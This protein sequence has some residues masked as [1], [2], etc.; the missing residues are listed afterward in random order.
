MG[1]SNAIGLWVIIVCL[2]TSCTR[3]QPYPEE[4][5][6]AILR[7]EEQP[8]SARALLLL[9]DSTIRTA[10]E[11]TQMYYVLLRAEADDKLY[12][13]H[14]TDSMMLQVADYYHGKDN[15]K[16]QWAYYLLGRIYRNM[17]D[18]PRSLK[19]YQQ[20]LDSHP[21][22]RQYGL[23][24]RIYEQ[25]TYIYAEQDLDSLALEASTNCWRIYRLD[26]DTLG[27]AFALRNK[28]RIF[29]MQHRMDSM[30]S[31]YQKSY[32]T[33]R[34]M[35]DSPST[36]WILSEYISACMAHDFIEQGE[37]LLNALPQKMKEEDPITCYAVGVVY[38]HHN[39]R[40]S[41]YHYFQKALQSDN[42]QMKSDIY[43]LLSK[44]D[45]VEGNYRQAHLNMLNSL[46]L[47][48]TISHISQTESVSKGHA[49]Y[50]YQQLEKKND[51]LLLKKKQLKMVIVFIVILVIVLSIGAFIMVRRKLA[52]EREKAEP[53]RQ[54]RALLQQKKEDPV[55]GKH[56]L[57]PEQKKKLLRESDIYQWIHQ[58]NN[59]E[60]IHDKSPFWEELQQQVVLI[61]PT[62][63]SD[64][65]SLF[66][67]L[68]ESYL[69]LSL[70]IKMEV[71]L[72]G[73]AMMLHKTPSGISNLRR[74]LYDIVFKDKEIEGDP[75]NKAEIFDRFIADL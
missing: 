57:N 6:E 34:T 52:K 50:N 10:P 25:M 75:K 9:L 18:S 36:K 56:L 19:A 17:G 44:L 72:K 67:C 27:V 1:I 69:R 62:F 11:E 22:S 21:E 46:N 23:L 14:T 73:I 7:M 30:L 33:V 4:M 35:H 70:L 47:K 16:F 15:D 71:P 31:Y 60:T 26:N 51:K 59:W 41:M 55:L 48:D 63:I 5:Q 28:A 8:D 42:L 24:G 65:C 68:K 29:E 13:S 37:E 43:R 32:E 53:I 12:I 66:P 39:R 54:Q 20:A 49:L 3:R 38:L 58:P 64:L 40:D 45:A 74:R 2:I 61:Y